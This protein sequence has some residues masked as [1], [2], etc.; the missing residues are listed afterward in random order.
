[1]ARER[2]HAVLVADITF[3]EQETGLESKARRG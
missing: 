3:N 1:M 2:L